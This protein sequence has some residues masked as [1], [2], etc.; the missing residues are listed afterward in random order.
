MRA[1]VV[2]LATVVVISFMTVMGV[3]IAEMLSKEFSPLQDYAVAC[4]EDQP[5]WDCSSMGNLICGVP[6]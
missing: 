6:Q 5:C 1:A 4:L 3:F 2:N